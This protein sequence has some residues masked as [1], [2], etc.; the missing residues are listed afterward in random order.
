MKKLTLEKVV[1]AITA[2]GYRVTFIAPA[3]KVI[4][5]RIV[6]LSNK[7]TTISLLGDKTGRIVLMI[8]INKIHYHMTVGRITS[9][10]D[11]RTMLFASEGVNSITL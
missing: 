3:D 8:D 10:G 1:N 6:F 9:Q 5:D 11:K 4:T 7:K 2:R